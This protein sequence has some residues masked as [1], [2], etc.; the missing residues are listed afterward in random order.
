MDEAQMME[1]FMEIQRGL[2]RQGPGNDDA[3]RYAL[4]CCTD[5][6]ET[7]SVLDIGCGPGMQTLVLADALRG[8]I[9]AVD[10]HQEYLDELENRAR[11]KG[12]YE[13]ITPACEDMTNLPYSLNSFD[14]I[15][16]EGSAYIMGVENAL[17]EWKRFLMPTGYIVFSELLW[18]T[19]NP[20]DEARQFFEQAYPAMSDIEHNKDLI[21]QTGYELVTNFTIDDKAWWDDYYSPLQERLPKL[22]NRYKDDE[23][24]LGFVEMT[25]AEIEIRRKYANAYGYEVFVAQLKD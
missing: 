9:T 18:L 14:L 23:Q 12:L 15:W 20:P 25:I 19:D 6:P 8:S 10:L 13:H 17:R 1:I 22:R 5:L 21:R 3:T 11:T 4:S 2:P 16:S 7:P 24:A